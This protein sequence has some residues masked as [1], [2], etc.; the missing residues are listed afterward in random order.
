MELLPLMKDFGMTHDEILSL[1]HSYALPRNTQD[2]VEGLG[3]IISR[4][5][6]KRK[7]ILISTATIE[8]TEELRRLTWNLLRFSTEKRN[9][10]FPKKPKSLREVHDS[11]S[12]EMLKEK[13]PDGPLDQEIEFINGLKVDGF[14]IEVPT[15]VH[16]LIETSQE[17]KHCVHSYFQRVIVKKCQIINLCR[18]GKRIYTIEL[19]ISEG[20]YLITQFKGMCNEASM[21]GPAGEIIRRK[22]LDLV[23]R[24]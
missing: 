7:I 16:D 9:A 15:M 20:R 13:T 10:W 22:I 8:M 23:N 18:E 12:K 24:A 6:N 11:L 3:F 1:D 2:K 17:L 5:S 14:E 19:V 4:Y 21:Q